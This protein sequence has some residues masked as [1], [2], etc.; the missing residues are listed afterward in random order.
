MT[1]LHDAFYVPTGDGDGDTFES[2]GA[3]TSPWDET[4]QHGGPPAALLARAVERSRPDDSMPIARIT[5]DMLGAIPQGRIRTEA[6]IVRPGRR[7]ELVEAR[8]W[9]NDTLAVSATA[10]RIRANR[11][12]TEAHWRAHEVPPIGPEEPPR[13]FDGVSSEWGYGRAVDWRFAQGGINDPGPVKVW[14]RV[15][16]PL[17]E[18]EETTPT[19]R[20]L[21]VADAANGVSGGLPFQQ[22]LFIPPTM[23]ATIERAPQTEWMLLDASTTVGPDGIGLTQARMFDEV[24]LLAAVTQPLIVARR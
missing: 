15:R 9:A 12:S 5:V 13:Y 23:T 20:L 18:G 8:L 11:G 10:W 6:R 1:A 7:I 17:V 3:T 16:I 2:T 24:G 19:Q 14:T 4:M 21:V 22:W